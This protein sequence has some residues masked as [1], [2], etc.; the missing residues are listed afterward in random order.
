[1]NKPLPSTKNT[2]NRRNE[3]ILLFFVSVLL[4]GLFGRLY[5]NL[6]PV[7]EETEIGYK[8]GTMLH[9]GKAVDTQELET[10]LET[11]N[12]IENAQELSLT[13]RN[14]SQKLA[15]Q[16]KLENL[17]ALNKRAFQIKADS[18]TIG[19]ERY[20]NAKDILGLDTL[21]N[22][23]VRINHPSEVTLNEGPQSISGRVSS[24]ENLSKPEWFV[25][26]LY[27]IFGEPYG[28]DQANVLIRLERYFPTPVGEE[29]KDIRTQMH[30][31]KTDANGHFAFKGLDASGSYSVIPLQ[32]GFE[33]GNKQ[34]TTKTGLLNEDLNLHFYSKAHTIKILASDTYQ[35]IK[36]DK[37][38]TVRTPQDFKSQFLTWVLAFFIAFWLVHLVWRVRHFEGDTLILPLLMTLTGISVL[39]MF[40]I[41]DPLRD[42]LRGTQTVQGVLLGL[43][44]LLVMSQIKVAE[45]FSIKSEKI[46]LFNFT[47]QKPAFI[48][49][50]WTWLFAAIG[51]MVLLLAFGTGPEGSGVKVNLSFF[52]PSEVTK[53]LVLLFFAGYFTK[54]G[55]FLRQ[56]PSLKWRWS[57]SKEIFAGFAFLLGIYLVLGD[58]GPAL[59]LCATFLIFYASVRGELKEMLIG[60]LIYG[61]LLKGV[62]FLM[63]NTTDKLP[64]LA[65]TVLYTLLCFAY[66]YIKKDQKESAFFVMLL[67]AAFVFGEVAPKFGE[68][69]K[70]R[71]DIWRN[72]WDNGEYGGDQIAH[73]IW[74][75][76]SGGWS[77]QGLGKG[78]SKVMPAN[79]T[80]MIL[81]SI[82][83]EMGFI[84]LLFVIICVG[85]L[86]YRSILI[87]RRAGQDFA[88]YLGAGIAI[89]TGAQFFL[90]ASGSVGTVPL[91]GI[92][93][94][95]LSFGKAAMATNLAAFGII[96]SISRL[97]STQTQNDF[98]VKNYDAII[99]TGRNAFVTGLVKMMGVF[100]VYQIFSANDYIVKPSFVA[101]RTGQRIYSQ[102][103]RIDILT[104]KLEAGNIYDR[105]GVLL[106]TSN[107][108]TLEKWRDSL[109]V[110][111]ASSENINTILHK[112]L[113]RYYPFGEHLLFWLGDMNEGFSFNKAGY[114]AE[115]RHLTA[116]RGFDNYPTKDEN[117]WSPS[118]RENGFLPPQNKPTPVSK[119]D[120]SALIPILKAGIDTTSSVF[121][122]LKSKNR[123]IKLSVDA[124]LQT[125]IQTAIQEDA[126][127][128][129]YRTSVVVL[130]P[131]NGQVLASA[132][133]PLPKV[134]QIQEL[135][136][137]PTKNYNVGF[138]AKFGTTLMTD[139]DL[140]ITL[141]TYPGSTAKIITAFAG[142]NELGVEKVR[143]EAICKNII[144][145]ETIMDGVEPTGTVNM[146]K[147]IMKSSNVYFIWLANKYHLANQLFKLY[148][149]TGMG[150]DVVKD[151]FNYFEGTNYFGDSVSK[152][153]KETRLRLWQ[154]KFNKDGTCDD[155]LK[156]GKQCSKYSQGISGASWGQNPLRATPLSIARMAGIIKNGGVF[157]PS[158][159]LIEQAGK[160]VLPKST[161]QVASKQGI[162]QELES[163][164]RQ[165]PNIA[166][167]NFNLPNMAAKTGTAEIYKE[168]ISKDEKI[169]IYDGW[170]VFFAQSNNGKPPVAVCVRVE[171]NK[172]LVGKAKTTSSAQ[173]SKLAKEIV[174]PQLAK[175]FTTQTN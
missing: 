168:I 1:M 64:Y 165:H 4:L 133:Y 159:F 137:I 121:K 63:P 78:F 172:T 34:G 44:A 126:D 112:R 146:E 6:M 98:I 41:Q 83:E 15:E 40:A 99:N 29:I 114:G 57:N 136:N 87:A 23:Q 68:R 92:S 14:L 139:R 31:A 10:L 140:G 127:F 120:Y 96:L 32:E 81:P 26:K 66:G 9:L 5:Y 70:S 3:T 30:Y 27:A 102:N 115:Y 36:D 12:Y 8:K 45:F 58:M 142:L 107:S 91:T 175:Y 88:F 152:N 75:L 61:S 164:M 77:G 60:V 118:F 161:I 97:R 174:E 80:D 154:A 13:V 54:N 147:A 94:P 48:T 170:F 95:F 7:F 21:Y 84:G 135:A 101:S 93:V 79:H 50:S 52:Q 69:L 108:K 62:S 162:S 124:Q 59:V 110:A 132:V 24:K 106:A 163:Y 16:G 22:A 125:S 144:F 76:A 11:N 35:K 37:V 67:I 25:S 71:N 149:T 51:L 105:N 53:Y 131:N 113:K 166:K 56:I 65:V 145:D 72:I 130:N 49:K 90:I 116:L 143:R 141:P 122:D 20:I 47:L 169:G 73:G 104:R 123:D 55:T 119:Y 42:T 171:H 38:F 43:L 153:D 100:F 156:R 2:T 138:K 18:T 129:K 86:L 160:I 173:A 33:F 150:M 74:S 82:G 158:Q 117:I 148:E 157:A 167:F 17:G 103:P 89:V 39:M 28:K 109:E 155:E 111:G 46:Q 85:G 134:K 19:K 151:K 128:N